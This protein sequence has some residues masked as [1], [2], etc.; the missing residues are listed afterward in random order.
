MI[1]RRL[2]HF[3]IVGE[4]DHGGMGAVYRAID[5][6]LERSVTL[7]TLP[8]TGADEAHRLRLLEEA[9]AASGLNHPG[10]VTIYMDMYGYVPGLRKLRL[11]ELR[12]GSQTWHRFQV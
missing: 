2:S 9:R 11:S 7:K 6:D 8:P 4:I 3:E 1:G 12:Q 5:L 10:I